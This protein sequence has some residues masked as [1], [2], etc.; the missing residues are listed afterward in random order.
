M[1]GTDNGLVASIG[2][3]FQA[4]VHTVA[5]P[6]QNYGKKHNFSAAGWWGTGFVTLA[7][8]CVVLSHSQAARE[9]VII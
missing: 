8:A 1:L 5:G 7:A 9:E 2:I 6:L 4:V 3:P